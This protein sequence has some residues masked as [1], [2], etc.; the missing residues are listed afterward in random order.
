MNDHSVFATA[1][2]L[3]C[4]L[5]DFMRTVIV[6]NTPHTR[7]LGMSG[8]KELTDV[9]G[10]L[11]VYDTNQF[12]PFTAAKT[13]VPLVLAFYDEHGMFLSSH[14]LT[15]GDPGPFWPSQPFR[16]AVEMSPDMFSHG[17]LRVNVSQED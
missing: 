10:M 3:N 7:S 8:M 14:E 9:D 11:F 16:Y 6:A 12:V 2:H 17:M 5:G 15:P 13:L 1:L 4:S